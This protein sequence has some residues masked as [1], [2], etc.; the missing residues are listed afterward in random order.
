MEARGDIGFRNEMCYQWHNRNSA[1]N[2]CHQDLLVRRNA[3]EE[4]YELVFRTLVQASERCYAATFDVKESTVKFTV[5]NA[6]SLSNPK[7]TAEVAV[8]KVDPLVIALMVAMMPE[9]ML[10]EH[11]PKHSDVSGYPKY[12]EVVQV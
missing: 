11:S 4:I 3:A 1:G 5:R 9:W 8:D 2:L 10:Y 7:Y 12:P 6:T